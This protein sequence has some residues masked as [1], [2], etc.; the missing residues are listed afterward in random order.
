VLLYQTHDEAGKILHF[1]M[2][3]IISAITY[4][5]DDLTIEN[6]ALKVE[7]CAHAAYS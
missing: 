7:S 3:G 6:E 4:T 5:A 2:Y 1:W